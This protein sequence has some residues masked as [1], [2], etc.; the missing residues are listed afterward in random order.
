M[1]I[2]TI[3][4]EALAFAD[5]AVLSCGE[6]ENV[7]IFE[8][9]NVSF[10]KTQADGITE[11]KLKNPVMTGFSGNLKEYLTKGLRGIGHIIIEQIKAK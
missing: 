6:N 3:P 5:G 10:K 11:A 7:K 2:A 8:G 4:T 9:D 1:S